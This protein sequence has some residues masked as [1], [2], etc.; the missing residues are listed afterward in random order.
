MSSLEDA[1]SAL[2]Q[3]GV[4]AFP[5]DTVYGLLARGDM[6]ESVLRIY[7]I[8]GRDRS[9]PLVLFLDDASEAHELIL[10]DSERVEV[11]AAR[12]WPG[13]LTIVF[14]ASERCPPL[15]VPESGKIGVR[16][17]DHRE[18]LA[19]L[20]GLDA[21]VASTS[22]NPS[23]RTPYMSSEEVS[24][25]L[26]GLDFVYPGRAEGAMPSTAIDVSSQ[27][28]L[29]LRKGGVSILALEEALR[30]EM[31]LTGDIPL[32]VLF[33]CTGNTCRSTMAEYLLRANLPPE[34]RDRVEIRSVGTSAPEGFGISPDVGLILR[35]VGVDARG[36]KSHM[37]APGDVEW[38]DMILGMSQMH[39]QAAQHIG[40]VE[41]A[42]LFG[43]TSIGTI[44]DPYGGPLD[45]YREIRD[46][47][48]QVLD[49]TWIPYISRKFRN[50]AKTAKP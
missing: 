31:V 30:V 16:V 19:L 20:G 46:L 18:L 44:P 23:G 4:I 22:A 8:K 15:L 3:G 41:K 5:T 45:G 37:L 1:R 47:I 33:L 9:K 2:V 36:F 32:R 39:V 34:L 49:E 43:G 28:P 40:A 42:R 14:K 50:P 29:V 35:E 6:E 27:A 13:P 7:E 10:G 11:L 24:R 25:G 17:P 26:Q 38:A 21:P 12:F 48:A